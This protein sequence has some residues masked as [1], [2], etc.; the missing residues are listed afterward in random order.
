MT[1]EVPAS[2]LLASCLFPVAGSAGRSS[3]SAG[4]WTA[5]AYAAPASPLREKR[6]EPP[7]H[8]EHPA[9]TCRAGATGAVLD[10][11]G[12]SDGGYPRVSLPAACSRDPLSSNWN[13]FYIF[14]L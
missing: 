1:A 3:V 13:I 8:P 9:H 2:P 5:W 11:G 12:P 4:A 6:P 14:I 10:V 7:W